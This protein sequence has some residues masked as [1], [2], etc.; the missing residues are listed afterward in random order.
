MD[1]GIFE[2]DIF[3]SIDSTNSD[4]SSIEFVLIDPYIFS[5]LRYARFKSDRMVYKKTYKR[6]DILYK[7]S[8]NG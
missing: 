6:G 8:G 2:Y 4:S 7:N 3:H 5:L 1:N